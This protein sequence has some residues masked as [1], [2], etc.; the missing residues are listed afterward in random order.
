M[1]LLPLLPLAIGLICS[2]NREPPASPPPP[3]P[4]GPT[5]PEEFMELFSRAWDNRDSAL[6]GG[7]LNLPF[8]LEFPEQEPDYIPPNFWTREQTETNVSAFFSKIDS[9]KLCFRSELIDTFQVSVH[10]DSILVCTASSGCT[11]SS[12]EDWVL[13]LT[14][15][16]ALEDHRVLYLSYWIAPHSFGSLIS[17]VVHSQ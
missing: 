2:C 8:I 14:H 10:V 9:T 6:F 1:R 16:S 12:G 4:A 7:L 3:P 17:N 5:T 13:F 11:W 15:G